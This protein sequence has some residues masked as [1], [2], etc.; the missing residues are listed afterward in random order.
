M[1]NRIG[2]IT[3]HASHNCGSMLQAYALQQVLSG[4]GWQ[5]E[6]V[7]FVNTGSRRLYALLPYVNFRKGVRGSGMLLWFKSL[8][9]LR[10]LKRQ[11]QDYCY[12]YRNY[13][14]RTSDYYTSTEQLKMLNGY[15]ALIAGSDQIWNISCMDADDAYFLPF[16]TKAKKI[17]YAVS[18]GSTRIT[19]SAREIQKYK[20]YINDFDKISV[21]EF[22]AIKQISE[23]GV[24]N[25]KIVLDPSLLF[26]QEEWERIIDIGGPIVKGKY[27]FYYAFHYRPEINKVIAEIGRKYNM[28]V[29][30]LDAKAWGAQGARHNGLQL[31]NKFGPVA[32][33]NLIKNASLCFTTS[34]HGTAFSVIFKKKFWFVESTMHNPNDDRVST[35]TS[36]LGLGD[37][38]ICIDKMLTADLLTHVDYEPVFKKL[39]GKRQES[40]DF[41]TDALS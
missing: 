32:F 26:S 13:L 41:L 38:H 8:F 27:F 19:E 17:A 18:L 20:E 14:K 21:R 9:F 33:L 28:P 37:R 6:I 25:V 40:L 39:E 12:F 35:L 2:I 23:L 11:H 1:G 31:S 24:D 30:I 7:D 5:C 3:F 10:I 29:Y 36:M 34:F 15:Y 22:N 4:V 16:K